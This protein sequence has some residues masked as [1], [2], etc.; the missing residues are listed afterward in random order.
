MNTHQII[1]FNI[2]LGYEQF[3]QVYQ[4]FAKNVSV[5]AEDG[6]R[7]SFPAM[8]IQSYLTKD[9]INGYF[10]MELTAENKFISIKKLS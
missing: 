7:V 8:N 5:L 10:E 1:R 4:G 2:R 6:R 9:G 3:L